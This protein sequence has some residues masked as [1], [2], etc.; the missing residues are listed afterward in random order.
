M[1]F[2]V[3]AS[4]DPGFAGFSYWRFSPMGLRV[5]N[6][7]SPSSD[8]NRSFMASKCFQRITINF[9]AQVSKAWSLAPELFKRRSFAFLIS[10]NHLK[11]L[12]K[13]SCLK[14]D[15]DYKCFLLFLISIEPHE[16]ANNQRQKNTQQSGK[17]H[18]PIKWS[19]HR[20]ATS[21]AFQ[22]W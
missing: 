7:S 10:Q 14:G 9:L 11:A 5:W 17:V 2:C 19:Q 8:S 1:E 3:F 15:C 20:Q 13:H 6:A 21:S 4:A 12:F 16:Q 18:S 22:L